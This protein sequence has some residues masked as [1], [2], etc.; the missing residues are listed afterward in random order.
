VLAESRRRILPPGKRGRKRSEQI[1]AAHAD[2]SAG[3]RGVE[4]YRK[5]I[6]GFEHMSRWRRGSESRTLLNAIHSRERRAR[7]QTQNDS[8]NSDSRPESPS[9]VVGS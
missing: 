5:Y 9:S 2:W 4:L 6:P 7:K 3:I 8:R 1:T